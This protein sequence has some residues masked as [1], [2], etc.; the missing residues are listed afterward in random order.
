MKKLVMIFITFMPFFASSQMLWSDA[1]LS[2]LYGENYLL[3]HKY[4]NVITLEHAGGHNWG[5][6]FF[7]IDRFDRAIETPAIYTEV[8]PRLSGN[9]LFDDAFSV[10]VIKDVLVAGRIEYAEVTSETNYLLGLGAD[11]QIPGFTYFK[12]NA[13]MRKNEFYADNELLMM[14][15][16]LPFELFGQK[17]VY[18][19][20]YDWNSGTEGF[21]SSFNLNSQLKWQVNP[22]SDNPI[23]IGIEYSYWNNKFGVQSSTEFNTNERNVNALLKFHF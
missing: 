23:Y 3:G 8:M 10:G 13:L 6:H 19:G 15:W 4:R 9:Y 20:F 1:S 18:D 5:D 22:A 12:V 11:L 21:A 7:F 2:V 17:F 16:A 14:V